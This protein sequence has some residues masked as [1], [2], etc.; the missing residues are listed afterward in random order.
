MTSK[1]FTKRTV[2]FS[3]NK[4]CASSLRLPPISYSNPVVFHTT[5][6]RSKTQIFDAECIPLGYIALK[7][8]SWPKRRESCNEAQTQTAWRSYRNLNDAELINGWAL[9]NKRQT[10]CATYTRAQWHHITLSIIGRDGMRRGVAVLTWI[11]ALLDLCAAGWVDV[12]T[13][14]FVQT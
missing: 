2:L 13:S 10:V 9:F 8:T 11:D 4:R 14:S 1:W 3:S 6:Q 7:N 5:W 12:D